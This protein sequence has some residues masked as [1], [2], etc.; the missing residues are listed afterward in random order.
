VEIGR[1]VE[2]D[3]RKVTYVR[4][5]GAA[6]AAVVS[7][8]NVD[9]LPRERKNFISPDLIDFDPQFL[10]EVEMV[11]DTGHRVRLVKSEREE[12]RGNEKYRTVTWNVAEPAGMPVEGN[13]VNEFVAW[14]LEVSV[15]D[16]GVQ[17]DLK[18]FGLDKPSVTLTLKFKPK[19]G[20]PEDR[21]YRIGRPGDSRFAYLLK[22]GSD[23]VFQLSEEIWR[24]LDRTDLNF[25]QMTM[26]NTTA[27]AIVAMSF[28]YRA[29]HLS[30]NPVRYAVRKVDGKWV[31]ENGAPDAKIDLDRMDVLLGQLNYI[32]AEGFLTRNP[33]IA[34]EYELDTDNPMGRLTIRYADP[35][36]PGKSTEKAFRFSK[37]YLDP[38][39][40]ARIYYCKMEPAK[41]DTSPSSDATIVFR[42]KTTFVELL[43]QG[44]MFEAKADRG[45]VP[46]EKEVP[47]PPPPPPKKG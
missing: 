47:P 29:D 3:A 12:P 9:R 18:S 5:D 4:V 10:Q 2:K 17:P 1:T 23:E 11:T 25:R 30:A 36:N 26:F 8:A 27:G 38:S 24:R 42:I 7:A 13:T 21:V 28:S 14:L 33:R 20:P 37:S 40:A 39:G 15:S 46:G 34:R 41:G 19:T 31:F 32:R 45:F 16:F 6:E 43:R 44:V 35:D 22:P